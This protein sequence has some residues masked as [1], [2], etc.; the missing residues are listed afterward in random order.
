MGPEHCFGCFL[1]ERGADYE[2]NEGQKDWVFGFDT[3]FVTLYNETQ[4]E[5]CHVLLRLFF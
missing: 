1:S 5:F 3:V 2:C 4:N